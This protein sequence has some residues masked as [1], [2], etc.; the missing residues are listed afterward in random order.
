[1]WQSRETNIKT[2]VSMIDVVHSD[3]RTKT[4]KKRTEEEGAKRHR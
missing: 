1:M 2:H 3:K 4:I